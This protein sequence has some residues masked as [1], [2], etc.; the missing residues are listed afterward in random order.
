[1][2]A[3]VMMDEGVTHHCYYYCKLAAVSCGLRNGDAASGCDSSSSSGHD[4]K[5]ARSVSQAVNSRVGV[6]PIRISNPPR[7]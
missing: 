4:S 3:Q 5:G 1:M 6:T 2:D 7:R